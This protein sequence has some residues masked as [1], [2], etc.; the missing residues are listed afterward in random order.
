MA[1]DQVRPPVRQ[2]VVAAS[3]GTALE[4]YDFF[5]YGALAT[6]L[7]KHFFSG[8]PEAQAFILTLITFAAGFIARPFGALVFGKI[9]D[10]RGRKGAFLTTIVVMGVATALI[11][12]LPTYAQAGLFAPVALVALRIVQGFA[13]GGEYGGAAIFVAEYSSDRNRGFNTSWIQASAACGLI[14]ALVLILVLRLAMG[15]EAFAAW[16]WRIPFLVS[17]LLLAVSVWIRMQLSESPVFAAMKEEGRTS[18]FALRETFL[19]WSNLR[20]VLLALFALMMAQGVVFYT[21]YFYSQFFLEK[22]LKVPGAVVTELMLTASVMAAVLYVFFGWLSDRVGRKPVM[23]S[24]MALMLAA[25]FPGFGALATFA[26]PDLAQAQAERPVVV[27]ADPAD[28][29]L[30]L[31][32]TGGAQAFASSCD[33]AKSALAN[34]GVA[35]TTEA[36]AAGTPA[37]ITIGATT[38]AVPDMRGQPSEIR[39]AKKELEAELKAALTAAGYPASADMA[40]FDGVAVFGVIAVFMVAAT[41]LYGPL[42]AC[43]VELFPARI[44]YTALSFPYHVGTGW[45]GGFMP[46]IAFA[47]ITA[48]GD[49]YAGLWYPFGV[50]LVAFVLAILFLPETRGRSVGD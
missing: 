23:L 42:A 5:V 40:T 24:G 14:L 15:E 13:L 30:Q 28:C 6:I 1:M 46:A 7:A 31:D 25:Y 35:Y 41:A 11:G 10:S 3:V 43:L 17:V 2:V 20:L 16:G 48:T 33:M 36:A 38:L 22:I 26:N 49:I 18:R 32:L 9:G 19:Q 50:T 12:L 47:A 44:R 29:A 37:S 4:W 21:G 8:L 45:F 39:Q 34:A 27:R